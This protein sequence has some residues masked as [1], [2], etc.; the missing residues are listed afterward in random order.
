MHV[1]NELLGRAS[2]L[3][4]LVAEHAED[5]DREGRVPPELIGKFC[6]AGFMKI[7]VPKRYGGYELGYEVMAR[8][9]RTIA[10]SCT[11]TAW[12]LA[13]YMGHNFLH[14]LFPEQAQQEVFGDRSFALTP[15]TA[16]PAFSLTP[17]AG[18]YL[19][20]G[21]SSW[22][23]G[24][25][26]AEWFLS[27]GLTTGDEAREHR[28]FLVPAA[29]AKVVDNWDV[30]AMRGTSSDDLVLDGVFVPEHRTVSGAACMNGVSP[31]AAL[32]PNPLYSLPV[33]PMILGEV[34]PIMVGAYRR[35]TDEFTRFIEAR[36][37]PRFT[38]RTP[39]KQTAQIRVGK[40]AAGAAL[41]DTLLDD[42]IRM[43]TTT[44]PETLRDPMVRAQTK[45]R[46]A[47]I[48][49]IC[50]DGI[51]DLMVGA[52]AEAFRAGAAMQRF[53]RDTSMLRV[54]AYL[55]LE[56]ATETYGRMLLGLPPEAPV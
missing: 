37:G 55:D 51:N 12:V 39:G 14:A 26:A 34:I 31:G 50:A 43:L 17:V 25:S 24:A 5:V 15:G 28:L 47:L 32:H 30:I 7:M 41:A 52:G 6:D 20:T 16:A 21:R 10:P 3:A 42:Y 9:I 35:V 18:G 36:Q 19:A 27:G 45:A 29:E 33:L 2:E 46:A 38:T 56:S 23:S 53:F 1:S 54:H 40:G 11:S 13:F 8:V 44:A 4:P 22:N 49:D 48:T